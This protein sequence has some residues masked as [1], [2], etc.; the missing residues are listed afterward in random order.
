[1]LLEPLILA[2]L[3]LMDH[4]IHPHHHQMKIHPVKH[5]VGLHPRIIQIQKQITNQIVFEN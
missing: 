5:P 1:M 3:V 4:Q 2:R